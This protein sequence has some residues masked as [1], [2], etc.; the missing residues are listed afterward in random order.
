MKIFNC[1]I[2]VAKTDEGGG[3]SQEAGGGGEEGEEG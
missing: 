1:T 2:F 3:A